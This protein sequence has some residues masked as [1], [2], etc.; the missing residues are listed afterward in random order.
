MRLLTTNAVLVLVAGVAVAQPVFRAAATHPLSGQTNDATSLFALVDVGSLDGPL[1]RIAD[2]IAGVQSGNGPVGLLFGKGDG[3]FVDG[4]N[5]RLIATPSAM[6]VADFTGDGIPDLLVGEISNVAVFF[7]GTGSP[8]LAPFV[9]QGD[10]LP[11]GMGPVA[12]AT[13]DIDGDGKVD[14]VVIDEGTGTGGVTVLLG[15]GNGSFVHVGTCVAGPTP[16]ADCREDSDCGLHG[17][18]SGA[19]VQAGQGSVAVIIDDFNRDG[20]ADLAV[21]NKVSNDVT[22]LRGTAAGTRFFTMVQTIA[23]GEA[24][25]AIVASDLNGDGYIDLVVTN[26]DSDNIAVVEGRGDGSFGAARFFDTGSAG[27]APSGLALADMNRDGALDLLV[28]NNRSS[29]VSVLLGDGR[30]NFAA[31]RA[32]VAD[33]DPLALTAADVNGDGLPDAVSVNRGSQAPDVAV[34]LGRADGGLDGVE[35]LVTLPSPSA[36]VAG[37]VDNDG[38]ADLIVAHSPAAGTGGGMVLVYQAEPPHGFAAPISLQSA[39]DAVAIGRG[40]FNADGRLDIAVVNRSTRNV[41]VFLARAAG[42]FTAGRSYPIGAG[43]TAV[44]VGDWNHDGRSDLAVAELGT[45]SS[46]AI[47][48]LA[49]AI[50]GSFGAPLRIPVGT[51]PFSLETGDVNEDGALDLIVADN[52]GSFTCAG[53]GAACTVDGDCG[54]HGPCNVL[55]DISILAGDGHGMFHAA[56]RI[57]NVPG[58][59]ALVVAD[60]DRDHHDDVAVVLS[61]TSTVSIYFGDGLGGFALGP[62]SLSALAGR[63]INGDAIPDLLVS[64]QVGNVVA[65]Y[66]SLGAN[67]RFRQDA[68]V[69]VS[70]QPI[71]LVAADFDGNGRYDAAAAENFTGVVSVLTNVV[72]PSATAP[73]VLRGD[74]NGDGIVSAADAVAMMRELADGIGTRIEEV[75]HVGRFA[76]APGVDANGDGIVT[77]QDSLAVVHRLFQ[78]PRPASLL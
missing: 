50:D 6:A 41:T 76:A 60:F 44:V 47:E 71:G 21:V 40:D 10:P 29:D 15:Q 8:I 9:A 62:S 59:K 25:V 51:N 20:R 68:A 66:R 73:T 67:R 22:I 53:N 58:P 34:L 12:I 64:D 36:L 78:V 18:C 27:S 63:D 43:A 19:L 37:D 65:M 5:T 57:P 1:D 74:G 49:A 56:G 13:G 17:T 77:L 7:K 28:S 48:I 39:G 45:G 31:P 52:A 14:A 61:R 24:P 38:V 30:G 2:V 54:S 35:D 16:N 3:T 70:R 55:G 72:T 46:G 69:A 42:G 4:P 23:V 11:A 32:F 75:A 26:Q 33:Q